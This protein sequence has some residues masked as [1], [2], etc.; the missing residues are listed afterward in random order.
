LKEKIE[1]QLQ[2]MVDLN[3][4]RVDFYKRYQQIIEAY[5]A[6]KDAVT[7]EETFRQLIEFVNS[8]SAEEADTKREGLSEEQKAVFDILR[9]P[10]LNSN[11]KK[12]IK[13]IA[14]YLLEELKKE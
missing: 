8:L 4:L 10:N 12:K 13:E 9:K 11:D 1:K 3:P 14:I 7:I 2:K 5:N 6:G